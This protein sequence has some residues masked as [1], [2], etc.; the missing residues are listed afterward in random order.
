MVPLWDSSQPL[1]KRLDQEVENQLI[2]TNTLVTAVAQRPLLSMWPFQGQFKQ[3]WTQRYNNWTIHIPVCKC[4]HTP[5]T[6]AYYSLISGLLCFQ[7]RFTHLITQLNR[8]N[9]SAVS[10]LL[11][12]TFPMGWRVETFES[13]TSN[14]AIQVISTVH[15]MKTCQSKCL[16]SPQQPKAHF[17]GTSA[18]SDKIA[19]LQWRSPGDRFELPPTSEQMQ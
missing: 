19:G 17:S 7:S 12:F 2:S 4:V 3:L 15:K 14:D 5:Q 8:G 18:E 13:T 6:A 10:L 11:T 9:Q 1:T 16:M